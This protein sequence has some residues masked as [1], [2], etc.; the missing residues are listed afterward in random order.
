MSVNMQTDLAWHM[1]F[2]FYVFLLYLV[3]VG[4]PEQGG[5]HVLAL[6]S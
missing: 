3:P 5:L 2:S 4:F 1:T 6:I